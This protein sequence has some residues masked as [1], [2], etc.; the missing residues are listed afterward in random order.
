MSESS[1]LLMNMGAEVATAAG[2]KPILSQNSA[3]D[4]SAGEFANVLKSVL[5]V[6]PQKSGSTPHLLARQ[7]EANPLLF[8]QL[9]DSDNHLVPHDEIDLEAMFGGKSLPGEDQKLAWQSLLA[10]YDSANPD[11]NRLVV[12][13]GMI[14]LIR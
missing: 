6:N 8:S 14:R 9:S 5:P 13:R 3:S 11:T 7:I 4:G 12:A 1:S 2:A 10:E